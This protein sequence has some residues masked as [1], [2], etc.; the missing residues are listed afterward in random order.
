MHHARQ[1]KVD[2][3]MHG[4]K[5]VLAPLIRTDDVSHRRPCVVAGC[6]TIVAL[7]YLL[8]R[9]NKQVVVVEWSN[10]RNES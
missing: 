7:F 9:A 6:S 4:S 1:Y 2:M 10:G 3:E 8:I 5:E